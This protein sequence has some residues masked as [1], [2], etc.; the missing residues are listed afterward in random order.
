MVDIVSFQP[1]NRP[2]LPIEVCE[3]IIDMLAEPVALFMDREI[4]KSLNNCR[5]VCRDE[6][7][8]DAFTCCGP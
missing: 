7:C 3:R 4:R 5:L 1:K 2:R 6:H 8:D